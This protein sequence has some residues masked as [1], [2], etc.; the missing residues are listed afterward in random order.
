[1]RWMEEMEHFG[2]LPLAVRF[3]LLRNRRTKVKHT[4]ELIRRNVGFVCV[5]EQGETAADQP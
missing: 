2:Q 1:M 4:R 5:S 3:G